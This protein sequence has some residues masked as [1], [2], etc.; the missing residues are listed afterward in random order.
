[1]TLQVISYHRYVDDTQ[2]NN[3]F[4]PHN[5]PQPAALLKCLDS[6]KG[7]MA[8]YFPQLN[9]DKTEVCISAPDDVV[10]KVMES[11]GYLSS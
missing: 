11:L 9:T 2:L 6:I 5:L 1:M 7:W 4:K 8:D 10:Q 3:P